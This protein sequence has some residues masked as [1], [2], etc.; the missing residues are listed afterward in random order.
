M[1]LGQRRREIVAGRDRE[2]IDGDG[3]LELGDGEVE[4]AS[5]PRERADVD[6][7]RREA[8]ERSV[9]LLGAV[10]LAA[11]LEHD[12]Q[13]EARLGLIRAALGQACVAVLERRALFG[14][15]AV[16]GRERERSGE[17]TELGLALGGRHRWSGL[18]LRGDGRRRRP[19]RA[20]D[21]QRT[22][23]QGDS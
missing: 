18:D 3:P 5:R 22:Q 14:A 4:V 10:D 19:A 12:G 8:R 21:Q 6:E 17:L 7:R 20:E 16:A 15:Q 23:R 2:R 13:T 9:D 11:S 1:A